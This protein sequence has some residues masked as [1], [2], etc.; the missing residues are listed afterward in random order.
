MILAA[1]EQLD[2]DFHTAT[3]P[4]PARPDMTAAFSSSSPTDSA[5]K[6]WAR[7]LLGTPNRAH[8]IMGYDGFSPPHP[9]DN[10]IA[11]E[12]ITCALSEGR[13]VLDSWRTANTRVDPARNWAYVSH[14]ANRADYLH[15]VQT[16]ATP[17]TA[18]NSSYR[19]DFLSKKR[20]D[21]GA[22]WGSILS[23]QTA[24]VIARH[25]STR[26]PFGWLRTLLAPTFA[27]A[28]TPDLPSRVQHA[29]VTLTVEPGLEPLA[30]QIPALRVS[31]NPSSLDRLLQGDTRDSSDS[32]T[33]YGPNPDRITLQT[34]R[35][36]PNGTEGCST[37]AS[38]LQEYHSERGLSV[39]PVGYDR[40]EAVRRA[41]AFLKKNGLLTPDLVAAETQAIMHTTFDFDSTAPE[42]LVPVEYEV[43]FA[44]R[45]PDG[46][47]DGANAGVVVCLDDLGVREV[48]SRTFDLTEAK[49]ASSPVVPIAPVQ[50]LNAA[51]RSRAVTDSAPGTARTASRMHIVYHPKADS[52]GV[53][54]IPAW[55]VELDDGQTVYVD[56]DSGTLLGE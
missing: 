27:F 48:Y 39:E 36:G 29:S 1:C 41:T 19:I 13:T 55:R 56:A 9:V 51:V 54:L 10:D 34:E 49:I 35:I 43:R 25:D 6:T 14:Y 17:D 7:T 18:V 32:A 15:G 4:D 38:G 33:R 50:A 28:A 53:T 42:V 24:E 16:G 44:Q 40:R 47:I 21:S 30:T 31:Q 3:S 23:N 2:I 11:N 12:F 45:V 22:G 37:L 52:T 20:T 26:K 46:F 5:A 8:S